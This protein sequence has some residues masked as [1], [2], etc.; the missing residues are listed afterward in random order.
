MKN[1]IVIPT[2]N[3]VDNVVVLVASIFEH[4]NKEE[5][6]ILFVD[7]NSNDGTL[8]EIENL[9]T[10]YD[11]INLLVREK[12]LGLA[13]AYIDGFK[14]AKENNF[15]NVI[16]MDA[17]LSHNPKYLKKMFELLTEK[18][19]VIGS[20]YV[21]NAKVLNCSFYRKLL[22]YL[23]CFYIN[24]ILKTN[25]I[26]ITGGYNAW[27]VNLIKKIDLNK[28]ISKGYIFQTEMKY[29]AFKLNSKIIEIPIEFQNRKKGK[30][31]M[32]LKIVFEAFFNILK[33]N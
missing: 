13:T 33:F 7:D 17:D 32:D 12:K 8:I 3:E 14:F 25:I 28:I 2:Y 19:L 29:K 16:Q 31:K 26:D 1:L 15:D 24:Q 30:S 11:N 6:S 21:R 5:F 23:G 9:K 20:R 22:S 4:L 27:N 18:D 10:K